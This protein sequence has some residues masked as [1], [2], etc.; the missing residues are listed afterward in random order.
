MT[1][2][3]T[4]KEF[5]VDTLR[6]HKTAEVAHSI[7]SIYGAERVA[8]DLGLHCFLCTSSGSFVF[9]REVVVIAPDDK[10]NWEIA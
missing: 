9:Q 2:T 8:A 3:E 7:L 1:E 10:I 6:R 5:I 4:I